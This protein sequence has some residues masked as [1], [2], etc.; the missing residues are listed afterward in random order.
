MLHHPNIITIY[1]LL[2]D[3]GVDFIAMEYVARRET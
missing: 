2:S 1:D 3:Q